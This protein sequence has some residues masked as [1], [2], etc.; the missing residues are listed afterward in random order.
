MGHMTYAST[1]EPQELTSLKLD[2]QK[3]IMSPKA[4]PSLARTVS[5]CLKEV[6]ES[7]HSG[8]PFDDPKLAIIQAI[9][10]D[11]IIEACNLRATE[12]R[13]RVKSKVSEY[14]YARLK[15]SRPGHRSDTDLLGAL[16]LDSGLGSDPSPGPSRIVTE[17]TMETAT[18][19]TIMSDLVVNEKRPITRAQSKAPSVYAQIESQDKE[20]E[21]YEDELIPDPEADEFGIK[22]PALPRTQCPA[23]L[24]VGTLKPKYL[25]S[26]YT[27][28]RLSFP[29]RWNHMKNNEPD[30][31]WHSLNQTMIPFLNTRWANQGVDFGSEE[32]PVDHYSYGD[33][34]ASIIQTIREAIQQKPAE[35]QSLNSRP[36]S[37]LPEELAM[38]LERSAQRL[39]EGTRVLSSYATKTTGRETTQPASTRAPLPS[40]SGQGQDT[41][42]KPGRAASPD[43]DV[44]IILE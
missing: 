3:T 40:L 34:K 41:S 18:N 39:E 17:E 24:F 29:R 19:I 13:A 30:Q 8:L 15:A 7:L 6:S 27:T 33:L 12:P 42:R 43:S 38:R 14:I 37:S 4:S 20:D 2:N 16:R 36:M 10:P 31:A 23:S 21:V 35:N 5:L 28:D 9:T 22:Y 26:L 32:T 25:N 11:Q 1:H 44:D